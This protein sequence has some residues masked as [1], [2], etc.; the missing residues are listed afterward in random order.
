MNLSVEVYAS[1][2]SLITLTQTETTSGM[3]SLHW[4]VGLHPACQPTNTHCIA[5]GVVVVVVVVGDDIGSL[6]NRNGFAEV[7]GVWS[8]IIYCI[9]LQLEALNKSCCWS[10]YSS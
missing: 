10:I 5:W 3:A 2:S 4:C 8:N 6:V 7:Y 1:L 9:T